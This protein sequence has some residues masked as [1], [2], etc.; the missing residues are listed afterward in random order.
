MQVLGKY[1]K[2]NLQLS[3]VIINEDFGEN[4]HM[5]HRREVIADHWWNV[6]V[7][8]FKAVV[9]YRSSD[10][11]LENKKYAVISDD[12]HH[13][14]QSMHAFNKALSEEVKRIT[15]VPVNEVH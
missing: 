1:L 4:F 13:D 7:T 10:G 9:C 3:A 2:D 11:D 5:K 14:K 6:A 12:L 8:L 15:L